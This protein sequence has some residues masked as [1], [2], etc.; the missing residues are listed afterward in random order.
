[1]PAYMWCEE[2]DCKAQQ[3]ALLFLTAT[4]G[5]SFRPSSDNWQVIMRSDGFG[6][7][8]CRCPLHKTPEQLIQP[9]TGILPDLSR[10]H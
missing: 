4:G 8:L 6:P 7:V 9:A 10:S 2:K 1:M 5:L 3:P